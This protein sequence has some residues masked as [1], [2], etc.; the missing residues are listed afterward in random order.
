LRKLDGAA[1]EAAVLGGLVLSAGGSGL[2]SSARHRTLGEAALAAGPV[3]LQPMDGFADDDA[4][5]VATAVGA[6]GH[7]AARTEP[8]DAVDAA[9]ALIDASGCEPKGVIPGHVPGLYA[10]IIA[11]ALG[12][13][14][15]DAA[16]NGRAHP[17][18]KMGGMGLASQPGTT[19]WQAGSAKGLRVLVHGD[20][21]KTSNVMRA[22][23]VENGGLINAVRGPFAAD[24]V[25]ANGAPGAISFALALGEAMLM[26]KNASR[27][28]AAA[29]FLKG[30][31]LVEGEVSENTV[32]YKGGFDVGSIRIGDMTLGVYNEFMTAEAAGRRLASFPDFLGSLDPESGAPVAISALKS[33]TRIA[34]VTTQMR[35]IPLGAGVFDPAVY[36]EVEAAM[37]LELASYALKERN[38]A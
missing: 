9:R 14:V 8:R 6:P 36:P 25:R 28:G 18:V 32:V 24:F 3:C 34:I 27:V 21:M 10:W 4:L 2:A 11:A 13:P 22:A 35:N 29:R 5:L 30:S 23:A 38:T 1:L 20:L 7:A 26:A 33:G 15:A 12:I 37:G 19:I 31:V 17:T 16:T